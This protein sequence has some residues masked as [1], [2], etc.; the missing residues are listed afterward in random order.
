VRA[1]EREPSTTTEGVKVSAAGWA[2]GCATGAAG[3]VSV[4]SWDQA[5]AKASRREEARRVRV[6]RGKPV[7]FVILVLSS[8]GFGTNESN[9][10]G[11]VWTIVNFRVL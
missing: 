8:L 10:P 5:G 3:A 6:K 9:E 11:R 7:C 4:F 1:P 2:A